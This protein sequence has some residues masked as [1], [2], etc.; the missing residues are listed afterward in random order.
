M[1]NDQ[2]RLQQLLSLDLAEPL[3]ILA[4]ENPDP[5][6]LASA[7]ALRHLLLETRGQ[8]STVG[9]SGIVGRAE[10]RA[11]VELLGLPV[12][13]LGHDEWR[14]FKSF[15]LI[16]AQPHTGNSI[17]PSDVMPDIVIDHHPLRPASTQARFHDIRQNIGASAT[18]LT[19]YLREAGVEIPSRLATALLYGIRSETQDLGR[20]TF[21]ADLDAYQYLFGI[22]DKE[23]LAAIS[24]PPL[25]LSYFTQLAAALDSVEVGQSVAVCT[26]GEVRV[27][28][29]VPEM[30]DFIARMQHVQWAL[31][32]GAF[33]RRLYVSI[34]SNR[35]DADAGKLM[36]S[37]LDGVGT[38]GGHSMRAGGSAQF[39]DQEE[40]SRWRVLI[41]E[42]FVR[43]VGAE[44]E[45]IRLL[46]GLEPESIDA[47]ISGGT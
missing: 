24:Q 4:H 40:L 1:S 15:A 38:G 2:A 8:N 10:N 30:A 44:K 46:R 6:S 11:M 45:S 7:V 34:R 21:A 3:L 28:D 26:L 14:R 5:D 33:G 36:Q 47:T 42:R 13:S 19:N 41:R 22:A 31:C 37:V 23:T 27:P 16:D 9:Y 32:S 39:V 20:E 25:T 43:S 17:L 18:L 35:R 29:F 12:V